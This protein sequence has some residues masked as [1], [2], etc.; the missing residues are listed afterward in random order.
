M[1]RALAAA[2][3]LLW[4]GSA[5]AEGERLIGLVIDRVDIVAAPGENL[6][7]LAELSGLATEQPYSPAA[8]RRAVKVLY[9]LGR[10]ENV[11]VYAGRE[12]NAVRVRIELPPRPRLA[13][14]QVMASEVLGGAELEEALGWKI[15]DEIDERELPMRRA[16]VREAL[17]RLGHRQA[18]VGLATTPVDDAGGRALVVRI[19]EGPVT[20][21]RH[22]VIRGEPRAP[23]LEIAE[24]IDLDEGDVI[25]LDDVAKALAK[26]DKRYV[27]AGYYDVEIA[28]PEVR[29]LHT[30]EDGH[31]LADLVVGVDAGPKVSIRFEGN[32]VVPMRELESA[33]DVLAE[34]GTQKSGIDEARE[35][36]LARYEVRGHYR[37]RVLPAA[38]VTPDGAR[39]EVLF[40]IEEGQAARV[41]S[42]R[43]DGNTALDEDDLEAAVLRTV[44]DTIGDDASNPG[45]DPETVGAV[46]GDASA[47][48]RDSDQPGTVLP[49]PESIY[50][51]RA[52]DAAIEV[53]ADLYKADGYRDVQVS[54]PALAERNHG[55]L[56]DVTM[57]IEPGVRW[58]VGSVS[59]SGN[60]VVSSEEL[61]QL[62]AVAF[63]PQ[64][65]K[66][67]PFRYERALETRDAIL[68][69]YR[70]RGHLY[71]N[72]TY[73]VA[74]VARRRGGPDVLDEAREY[75]AREDVSA[76][77]ACRAA[78]EAGEP[79]CEVD[80]RFTITEG[81]EVRAR[82][83]VVR[84]LAATR[85]GVV[86]GEVEVEKGGV[87]TDDDLSTTRDNLLK[88]GM[89]ER[90]DVHPIGDE[91]GSEKDV[92]VEVKERKYESAELGGGVS[93]LDG[94]RLFVGYGH[95]NLAGTGLRFQAHGRVNYQLDPILD[96]L[97]QDE[98][99]DF[100][101]ELNTL[102]RIEYELSTGLSY[103]R[104][105]GLP[106]GFS[107]GVDVAALGDLNP[108]FAEKTF[109]G[110]LGGDY[111]GY[112]PTLLGSQRP[113]TIQ[114]QA[115]LEYA[116][117][118]CN[119]GA[120]RPE[121]CA[122]ADDVMRG[123]RI[124]GNTFYA[125]I[126]PRVSFDL[127]DDALDPR[128]GAFF[129]VRGDVAFGL[130][131]ESPSY[132]KVEG[133]ANVYVPLVDRLVFVST[134]FA[135]GIFKFD[136]SGDDVP[137]NKRLE[138]SQ[139]IRGWQARE[140]LPQ[141]VEYGSDGQ[142][143]DQISQGGLT[144]FALQSELRFLLYGPLWIAGFYDVGDLFES[145]K[146]SICTTQEFPNGS[147]TRCLAQGAGFGVRVST[148]I[149]PLA[150]DI[151]TPVTRRDPGAQDW[152]VHFSV[153]TF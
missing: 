138:A 73:V 53:V 71:A 76:Q 140:L 151:A 62:S 113:L 28:P 64:R 111:K 22:I 50:V 38:R 121:L 6:G 65:G 24:R 152:T 88:L 92:V 68:Q 122:S 100:Y 80:V 61:F 131:A 139:R 127:R 84:G 39:K 89:F 55:S 31:P 120:P 19:D 59:F 48:A 142:P 3:L 41:A 85:E 109:V 33:A 42:L 101:Q 103:P 143:V 79:T 49:D 57:K 82:E 107:T 135:G 11:F 9:G 147:V 56:I 51:P 67:E 7:K 40:Q 128:A 47:S 145:G 110:T 52:Y 99:R 16:R 81:P 124:E 150:L 87:L 78:L 116:S 86:R 70:N 104:I 148:P 125:T 77:R 114:L 93:T 115:G 45:A 66:V 119:Q 90:V 97:Y 144:L 108:A 37:A 94:P 27:E 69:H 106:S 32:G 130:E 60:E 137:V 36:I 96:L 134:L 4:A 5:R 153:G 149:G 129:E 8:V 21:L 30:T 25:D 126:G 10:F 14:I 83:I 117:L 17:E 72:V 18:A 105:F 1:T 54:P 98:V 133:R 13:R 63:D 20:R 35:R 136:A 141:D 102:N 132:G 112:R 2:A 75:R 95:A 118:R 29:D 146:P 43:F 123:D 15:G 44:A 26:L 46:F 23:P 34:L 91:A 74:P 12:G 58:L